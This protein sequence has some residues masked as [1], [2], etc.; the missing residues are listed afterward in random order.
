MARALGSPRVL[1]LPD[2]DFC[3]SAA[4]DLLYTSPARVADLVVW[5]E[6]HGVERGDLRVFAAD[7]ANGLVTGSTLATVTDALTY[8]P[9][10]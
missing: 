4:L 3:A 1:Y 9:F 5:L 2:N 8:N 7:P 6:E 10:G